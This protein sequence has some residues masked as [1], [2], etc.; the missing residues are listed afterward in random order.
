MERPELQRR[1]ERIVRDIDNNARVDHDFDA[2]AF[3]IRAPDRRDVPLAES[4]V[5]YHTDIQ[6]ADAI[7]PPWELPQKR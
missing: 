1:L 6:V 2:G 3:I 5:D 7:R 4:F